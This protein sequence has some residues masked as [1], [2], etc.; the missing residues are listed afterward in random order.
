MGQRVDSKA[1]DTSVALCESAGRAECIYSEFFSAY[2]ELAQVVAY[3]A[4]L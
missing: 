1:L 2:D 3:S 4:Q